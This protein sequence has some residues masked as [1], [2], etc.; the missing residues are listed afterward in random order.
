VLLPVL[1]C[2]V[3]IGARLFHVIPHRWYRRAFALTFLIHHRQHHL[4]V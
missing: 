3:P 1:L 4:L 2:C